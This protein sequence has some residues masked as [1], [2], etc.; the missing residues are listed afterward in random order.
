MNSIKSNDKA[1]VEICLKLEKKMFISGI[2]YLFKYLLVT[3]FNI[4]E[5]LKVR[6]IRFSPVK[7]H[8]LKDPCFHIQSILIVELF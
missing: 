2:Y 4:K 6:K 3:N 5:L 1:S 8:Q 7:R